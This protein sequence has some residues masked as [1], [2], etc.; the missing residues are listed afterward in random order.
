[1]PAACLDQGYVHA[2]YIAE[3]I[4]ERAVAQRPSFRAAII[5][6]GQIS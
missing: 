2:K 4:I 6:S 1:L 3:K 5:R